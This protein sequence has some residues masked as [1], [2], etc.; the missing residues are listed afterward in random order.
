MTLRFSREQIANMYKY[1]YFCVLQTFD[2]YLFLARDKTNESATCEHLR[3]DV[4]LTKTVLMIISVTANTL[5]Q[6]KLGFACNDIS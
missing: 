6:Y 5:L 1:Y 2:V 3:E 4:G